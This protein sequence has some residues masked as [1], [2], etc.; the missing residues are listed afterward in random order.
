MAPPK[1]FSTLYER[2]MSKVE[3]PA[4]Q[5]ENGCWIF[6]G[7]KCPAGYGSVTVWNPVRKTP[8]RK[9]THIIVWEAF[10]G[11]LPKGMTVDHKEYCDRACCNIDHLDPEPVPRGENAARATARRMRNAAQMQAW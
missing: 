2:V 4:D 9:R 11:S 3:V 7:N 10:Y 6:T 8:T 5:N 1:L